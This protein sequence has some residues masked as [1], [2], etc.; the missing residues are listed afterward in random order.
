MRMAGFE[1]APPDLKPLLTKRISKLGL[2]LEGS[3]MEG[4][5]AGLHQEL[6]TKGLLRFQPRGNRQ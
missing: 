5:V 1:T 2:K 4:F 3:P 6:R